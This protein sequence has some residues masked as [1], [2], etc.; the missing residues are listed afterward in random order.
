MSVFCMEVKGQTGLEKNFFLLFSLPAWSHLERK[1]SV[2]QQINLVWPKCENLTKR[3]PLSELSWNFT[4][5]GPE[6]GELC[7]ALDEN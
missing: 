2:K 3:T 7:T 6:T 1:K 5:R 4:P